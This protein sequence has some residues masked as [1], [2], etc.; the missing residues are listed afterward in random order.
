MDSIFGIT[1]YKKLSRLQVRNFASGKRQIIYT[2][3]KKKGLAL[4]AS[5]L[6]FIV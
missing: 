1:F 3:G 4:K 5:P 2:A 6:N